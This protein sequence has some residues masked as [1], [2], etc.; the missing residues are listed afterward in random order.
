[1]QLY[2]TGATYRRCLPGRAPNRNQFDS[3]IEV[4]HR[5]GLFS[6]PANNNTY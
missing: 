2:R 5:T 1:M 4:G 6:L 3:V